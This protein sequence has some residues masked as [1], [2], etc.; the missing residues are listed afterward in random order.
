MGCTPPGSSVHGDSLGKNA[1]VGCHVLLQEVFPTQDRTLISYVSYECSSPLSHQGS[2]L[3]GYSP[4]KKSVPKSS[5][6]FDTIVNEIIFI[7]S[8]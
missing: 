8:V 6:L 1:E 4:L 3:P 2:P 7:V 5:I